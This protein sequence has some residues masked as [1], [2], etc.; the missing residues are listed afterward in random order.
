M[1]HRTRRSFVSSSRAALAAASLAACA[2]F[3][4]NPGD[5]L[6]QASAATGQT[7][8][9][10]PGQSLSDVAGE[11]TGSKDRDV[12]AKAARALFDANPSA[13]SSHD[14]NKLKLGAVLNVPA[15]LSGAPPAAA[16]A[17]EA[18]QT[19][20]AETSAPASSS[21][22]T[23]TPAPESA[24]PASAAEPQASA[25]AAPERA[26]PEAASAIAA[27]AS[28]PATAAPEPASRSGVAAATIGL[29]PFIIAIVIV[30]IGVLLL[31][32]RRKKRAVATNDNDVDRAPR[33]FASLEEAQADADARNEA[34]R[35]AREAAAGAQGKSPARD[36]SGLAAAAAS[37]G[38]A[39]VAQAPV[40][41]SED[42][43]PPTT[44]AKPSTA[45]DETPV[46]ANRPQ[47]EEPFVPVAPAARHPDFVPPASEPDTHEQ[48]E[49][50][51][52]EIEAREAARREA[53]K[54][55]VE[56]REA[57]ARQAAA[58]E[59]E[60]REIR[61]R[62]AAAREALAREQAGHAG[63]DREAELRQVT[64]REELARENAAREIIAREAELR[65][66]QA[67]AAEEQAAEQRAAEQRDIE[68]LAAREAEKSGIAPDEEP[69]LAHRFPMPKFPQDAIQA[70]GSLEME[71]PPRLELTI[72]PP[73]ATGPETAASSLKNPP[74]ET[75]PAALEQ[76]PGG[77]QPIQQAPFMP[78][79]V[80]HFEAAR[81]GQSQAQSVAS[82]IEAGTA[83][84]ASVAG[85][86]ATKF[87]PLSLDFDLGPTSNATEALP[88]LTPGQLATIARNKLELAAEYIELGDLSG[89]RTLLQEVIESN[90]PATRQQAATLLST[91][92]PH[93]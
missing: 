73:G 6:A 66:L 88:A 47:P 72:K 20:P 59:A 71:L 90:D 9:V 52:R 22:D 84:A 42:A 79:P 54:W 53:E 64:E 46:E 93:S 67:R 55:E 49:Q 30:V 86:G 4:A 58:R 35:K 74:L 85:L 76:P 3:W 91:L 11:L 51:A 56:E 15:D 38:N 25:T 77:T 65:E 24:A 82:Q 68:E 19:A 2:M 5:A 63:A 32:M 92:A 43:L 41:P 33:T 50:H 89:A 60:E 14:I 21:A 18:Q 1:I 61:A 44:E 45:A 83:G 7:Y 28:A 40:A 26:T 8:A 31:R 36:Q 10:K 62:E 16:S 37:I 12:R 87:G 23:A 78:Q 17:P 13:F 80:A 57:A 70:L 34:L 69:V 27:P 48:R 75:P 39:E 81:Q 29:S